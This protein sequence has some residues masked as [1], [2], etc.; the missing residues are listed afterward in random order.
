[1][2]FAA[3]IPEMPTVSLSKSESSHKVPVDVD[4]T[5]I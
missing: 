3:Y 5:H 4:K 2:Q 1:M